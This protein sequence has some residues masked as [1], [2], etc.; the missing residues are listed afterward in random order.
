MPFFPLSFACSNAHWN[1]DV[2]KLVIA[3]RSSPGLLL[4][5]PVPCCSSLSD[6]WCMAYGMKKI[7]FFSFFNFILVFLS[8]SDRIL[9]DSDLMEVSEFPQLSKVQD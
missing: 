5:C 3:K 9:I 4:G 8:F 1:E 6:L 2:T 7:V